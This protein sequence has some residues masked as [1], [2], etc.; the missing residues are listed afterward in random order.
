MGN[1]K[2]PSKEQIRNWLAKRRQCTTSLPS[3]S[4][5]RHQLDWELHRNNDARLIQMQF[6]AWVDALPKLG[7]S[8]PRTFNTSCVAKHDKIG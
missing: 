4:E 8:I 1:I 2:Q 7:E 5:I 3:I 6:G